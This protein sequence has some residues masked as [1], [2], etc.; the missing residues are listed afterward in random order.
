MNVG[1]RSI[2]YVRS[3]LSNENKRESIIIAWY[4]P[5]SSWHPSTIVEVQEI[6]DSTAN[7]DR[8]IQLANKYTYIEELT[9]EILR[10]FISKVLIHENETND[11][12]AKFTLDIYFTHIGRIA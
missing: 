11:K 9:P 5:R 3:W 10:T 2:Y 6:N 12:H 8:F 4:P 1:K 7:V